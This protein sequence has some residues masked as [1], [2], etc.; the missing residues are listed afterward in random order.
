MDMFWVLMAFFLS[1]SLK[2]ILFFK[3]VV[4]YSDLVRLVRFSL[5]G[6]CMAQRTKNILSIYPNLLRIIQFFDK[7]SQSFQDIVP[8]IYV[9]N[10]KLS[11]GNG[12]D[13]F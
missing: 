5:S 7:T 10:F 3:T 13:S 9:E 6:A 12:I 1:R 11:V 8:E 4:I 2:V